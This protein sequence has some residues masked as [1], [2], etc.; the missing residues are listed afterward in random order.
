MKKLNFSGVP[1]YCHMDLFDDG[2]QVLCQGSGLQLLDVNLALLQ[3][4]RRLEMRLQVRV[5]VFSA[6]LGWHPVQLGQKLLQ[7]LK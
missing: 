6:F 4:E 1:T 7:V 2:L 3:R 5:S